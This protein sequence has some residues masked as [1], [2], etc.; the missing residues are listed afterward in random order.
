MPL[1][2]VARPIAR[3]MTPSSTLRILPTLERQPGAEALAAVDAQ[4]FGV[5]WSAGEF[6]RMLANPAVGAWLLREGKWDIGYICFQR[7]EHEAEIYRIGI[8]PTWQGR[9]YGRW[10]LSQFLEWARRHRVSRVLL[11]VREGNLP[12]IGLYQ[13]AGFQMVERRSNYFTAPP[14]NALILERRLPVKLRRQGTQH[15][16][17]APRR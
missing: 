13:A 11:E 6:T 9:G 1:L 8:V 14:E 15:L 4:V 10:L 7:V 12:A 17:R 2:A 5:S 3:L 16:R